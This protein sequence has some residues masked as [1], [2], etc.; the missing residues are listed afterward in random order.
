MSFHFLEK[1]VELRSVQELSNGQI[2]TL[3]KQYGENAK[4]WRQKFT[5]LLPEVE[6]RA[7]WK[8]QGFSSIFEFAFKL[9][10]LSEAQVRVALNLDQRF[11][12]KPALRTLL[13][14]GTVSIHKLV[15][16][17]AVATSE[18]AEFWAEQVQALPKKALETL[19]RD[20][21]AVP[22]L[23]GQTQ[24]PTLSE[25]VKARLSELEAKGID[26][27][28]LLTEFLDQREAEIE[29]EKQ[30]LGEAAKE[31]SR[32]I[33]ASIRRVLRKEHG[34]KCAV[35]TCTKPFTELHHTR[36]FSLAKSH[37]PHFLAPLCKEHHTIAHLT[38]LKVREKRW[39]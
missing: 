35:P 19:V 29:A 31:A 33:P 11:S 24:T 18:S 6:R 32:Y 23:P 20:E 8:E 15:R 5:G 3:A 34:S 30:T 28:A 2:Y 36:R 37:D 39:G 17:Q 26:V 13:E 22:A 9:A 21:R 38:D 16:V 12:D 7:V 27:N 4:L 1:P 10:G 14:E 25:N